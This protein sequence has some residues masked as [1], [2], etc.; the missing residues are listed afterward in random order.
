MDRP[1]GE[2]RARKAAGGLRVIAVVKTQQG[3]VCG[4]V[5]DGV[6]MAIATLAARPSQIRT[7]YVEFHVTRRCG[8][9]EGTKPVGLTQPHGPG[10]SRLPD[11]PQA[12]SRL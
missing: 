1:A 5:S 7:A 6:N 3:N 10:A 2:R 11:Q 9:R 8:G 4:S 12:A